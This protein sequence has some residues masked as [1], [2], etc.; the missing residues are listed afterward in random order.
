MARCGGSAIEAARHFFPGISPDEQEK[1]ANTYRKWAQRARERGGAAAPPSAPQGGQ[2]QVP[3]LPD[4]LEP[5]C[6]DLADQPLMQQLREL[7]AMAWT[8]H[9][10]ARRA[11]DHRAIAL[12][13]GQIAEIGMQLENLR[14][15]AA[16]VVKVEQT[17]SAVAAEL[18]KRRAAIELRAER[19]RRKAARLAQQAAETPKEREL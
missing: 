18:E 11:R 19:E 13:R 1:K 2:R 6:Y 14:Q 17:A 5:P 7:L 16:R 15:K 9:E 12:H 8:D 4:A 10:A 3:A